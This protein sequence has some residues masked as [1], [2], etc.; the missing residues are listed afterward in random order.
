MLFTRAHAALS[1]IVPMPHI[2]TELQQR[3]VKATETLEIAERELA[4]ALREIQSNERSNKTMISAALQVAF[5]QLRVA[6]NELS[7]LL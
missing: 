3:V 5:D 6:K 4:S 2:L 1:P 7:A